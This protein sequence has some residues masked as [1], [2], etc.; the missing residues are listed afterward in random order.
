MSSETSKTHSKRLYKSLLEYTDKKTGS[1][2]YV[3]KIIAD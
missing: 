3:I 2:K 1:D